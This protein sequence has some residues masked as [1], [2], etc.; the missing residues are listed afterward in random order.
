VMR[1]R[2]VVMAIVAAVL[3]MV[4]VVVIA[5]LATRG[6]GPSDAHSALRK[7]LDGFTPP[8]GATKAFPD[9]DTN[10]PLRLSRGWNSTGTALD[11]AC[12]A[13]GN[14]LRDWVG[15][16]NMSGSITSD[17]SCS[18]TGK[19]DGHDVTLSLAVFGDSAPQA[20]LTIG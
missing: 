4:C 1:N 8:T 12:S 5:T 10:D 15:A 11:V 17:V 9:A 18:Y 7:E 3:A 16:Q 13:W 20:V 6:D 19:K 2:W 14:A